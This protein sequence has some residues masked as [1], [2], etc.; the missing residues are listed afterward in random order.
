MRLASSDATSS[1]GTYVHQRN[2]TSYNTSTL[3]SNTLPNKSFRFSLK[4][5]QFDD[6]YMQNRM[7]QQVEQMAQRQSKINKI[8]WP[9]AVGVQ[10][11]LS[12]IHNMTY[13]RVINTKSKYERNFRRQSFLE[14]E[15]STDDFIGYETNSEFH[16]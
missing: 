4:T 11:Q 10:R 3:N 6:T 9:Y 7:N 16:G 8:D 13:N 15:K 12:R 5:S 1:Q 2:H 14:N